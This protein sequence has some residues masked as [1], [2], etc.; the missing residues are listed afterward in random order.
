M[1]INDP[2]LQG[3]I[4]PIIIASVPLSVLIGWTSGAWWAGLLVLM[5]L[6]GGG[7]FALRRRSR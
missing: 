1:P 3:L 4:H 2:R 5:A 6:A 7:I